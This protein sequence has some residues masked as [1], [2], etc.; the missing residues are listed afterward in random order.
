MGVGHFICDPENFDWKAFQEHMQY[1]DEEIERIK[2]DPR[3]ANFVK[4]ICNPEMHKKYLV[5]EVVESHGCIAGMRPGDRIFFKGLSILDPEL[6]DPWCPYIYNVYWFTFG[7]R[8]FFINGLDPNKMY[9][10]HSGC[11]DV[12]SEN[13]LGRVIYKVFVVDESEVHKYVNR[14]R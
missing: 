9:V 2:N 8:N 10:V 14:K 1:T 4:K 3:R 5:A 6:S 13:G 12:G 7:A 11:M